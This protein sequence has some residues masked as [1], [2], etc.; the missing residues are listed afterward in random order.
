MSECNRGWRTLSSLPWTEGGKRVRRKSGRNRR[1]MGTDWGEGSRYQ[2][3]WLVFPSLCFC[4]CGKAFQIMMWIDVQQLS[5]LLGP[6][7]HLTGHCWQHYDGLGI[8]IQDACHL[9]TSRPSLISH[10]RPYNLADT[11]PTPPPCCQTRY[12]RQHHTLQELFFPSS[13]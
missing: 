10:H 13:P 11:P 8:V 9:F 6:V 7:R 3:V 2:D 4:S 5:P 12:T 1:E